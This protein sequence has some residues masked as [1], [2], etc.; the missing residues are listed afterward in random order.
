MKNINLV[1]KNKSILLSFQIDEENWKRL[2]EKGFT[3]IKEQISNNYYWDTLFWS[4]VNNYE[5]AATLAPEKRKQA[6]CYH[7]LYLLD[8]SN[9]SYIGF[10]NW[11][12]EVM[13]WLEKVNENN[14]IVD[15]TI[16]LEY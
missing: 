10:C 5:L 9:G 4:I 13:Y 11:A 12:A 8:C 3:I 14:L 7:I 2:K 1:C 6:L 16:E 15:E